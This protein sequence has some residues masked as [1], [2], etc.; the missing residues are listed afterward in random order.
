MALFYSRFHR[1]KRLIELIDCW[2]EYAPEDWLAAGGGDT[3][4]LYAADD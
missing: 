1:K 4:R 2:L 3:R